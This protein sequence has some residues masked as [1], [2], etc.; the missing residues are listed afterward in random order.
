MF[1]KAYL[2]LPSEREVNNSFSLLC[3]F[4]YEASDRVPILNPVITFG[5]PLFKHQKYVLSQ[6]LAKHNKYFMVRGYYHFHCRKQSEES[7]HPGSFSFRA[8]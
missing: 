3:K 5:S 4:S 6:Y 8:P 1:V 7:F 2:P